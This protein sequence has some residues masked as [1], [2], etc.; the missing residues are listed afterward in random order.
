LGIT[1]GVVFEEVFR[2]I[3]EQFWRKGVPDND[4]Y[5][6]LENVKVP[7]VMTA[8]VVSIQSHRL[9]IKSNKLHNSYMDS[10]QFVDYQ[11]CCSI[12]LHI[13][14]Q[15]DSSQTWYR[16]NKNDADYFVLIHQRSGLYLTA[17][18]SNKLEI[19]GK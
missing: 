19:H 16:G 2:D 17:T 3:P 11:P 9:E 4:G 5:F 12:H 1:N 13:D 6:T 15:G 18:G 14:I 8:V 10:S 7:K